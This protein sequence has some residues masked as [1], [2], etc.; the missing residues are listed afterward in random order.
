MEPSTQPNPESS[1][2]KATGAEVVALARTSQEVVTRKHLSQTSLGAS[3]GI[4]KADMHGEQEIGRPSLVTRRQ[5]WLRRRRRKRIL[6]ALAIA[7]ALFPPMWAVYLVGWLIWRN[8]PAQK[9]IRRVRT[10]VRAL[11]K[12]QTGIALQQLQEA[13]LLNPTNNDA[14]Y[15]L[16]LLLSGQQ[17]HAEAA[18]ALSLVAERVPGLPEV[19]AAL[20]DAYV[21]TGES[22]NAVY[23]AQRLME[24]A[25]FDPNTLLK[26]SH[27]Y[28]ADGRLDLAVQALEQAPLHKKTL[29]TSLVQIHYRL[30]VLHEKRGDPTRALHHFDR[31]YSSDI[32][33]KDVRSRMKALKSA[34]DE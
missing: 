28:E 5:V 4:L 22:E 14:L 27:A 10:A 31:V 33:Y 34:H 30:G 13:H 19:E 6:I 29:T 23:H 16:G 21:A 32:S 7:L 12:N 1:S 25:P 9:S 26:L 20:V 24:V 18:E 11:E 2:K 17:R 15:W 8:R 3:R